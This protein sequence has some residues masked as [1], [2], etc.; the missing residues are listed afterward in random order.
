MCISIA[1]SL[2]SRRKFLYLYCL[3][4]ISLCCAFHLGGLE[5]KLFSLQWLAELSKVIWVSLLHNFRVMQ[6]E[7]V[8]NNILI[9]SGANISQQFLMMSNAKII[10]QKQV[11]GDSD[12][13]VFFL[14]R[15]SMSDVIW[16]SAAQVQILWG[17]MQS[18]ST[19]IFITARAHIWTRSASR[20]ISES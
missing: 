14:S 18:L 8:W 11:A 16:V 3:S 9:D 20:S 6:T 7:I 15:L 17:V 5:N 4:Q 12:N 13:F 1:W 10:T 19:C 2:R